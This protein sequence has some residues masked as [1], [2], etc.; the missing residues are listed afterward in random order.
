KFLDSDNHELSNLQ[1]RM[2]LGRF[3]YDSLPK[4]RPQS[5]VDQALD[6]LTEDLT[7]FGIAEQYRESLILFH[8]VLKWD[9]TPPYEVLNA[10]GK[11]L[12]S[13]TADHFQ[14]IQDMN[15]L[16]IEVYQTAVSIFLERLQRETGHVSPDILQWQFSRPRVRLK[17]FIPRWI[18][19]L[20]RKTRS[21]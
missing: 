12:L 8:H 21:K 15:A 10:R 7:C 3:E 13:F 14:Q 4:A 20:V 2:L 5:I 9:T 18:K 11:R 19:D 16:D 17:S 6:V 1:T